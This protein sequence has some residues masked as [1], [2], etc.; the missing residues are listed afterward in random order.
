VARTQKVIEP[1]W[2]CRVLSPQEVS[3]GQ[4]VVAASDAVDHC[5]NGL[6][7]IPQMLW[8]GMSGFG[9]VTVSAAMT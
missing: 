7:P 1:R 3:V 9:H 6:N 2:F 5:R 4:S 8:C